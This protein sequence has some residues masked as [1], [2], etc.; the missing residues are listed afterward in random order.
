MLTYPLCFQRIPRPIETIIQ[1]HHVLNTFVL[2]T[3][4]FL[5][6]CCDPGQGFRVKIIQSSCVNK[7]ETDLLYKKRI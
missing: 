7:T 4:D 2:H 6:D 3:A 1:L 5:F